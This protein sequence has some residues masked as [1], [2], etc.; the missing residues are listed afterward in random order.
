MD[1]FNNEE[2][3]RTSEQL[4]SKEKWS[5]ERLEAAG[6]K[7]LKANELRVIKPGL[8]IPENPR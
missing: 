8:E 3:M 6:L 4:I 7:K 5:L 1:T 2:G